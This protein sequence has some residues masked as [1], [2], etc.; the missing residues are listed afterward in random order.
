MIGDRSPR[1]GRALPGGVLLEL[2][3]RRRVLQLDL[4][5][6][7]ER[8]DDDAEQERDPPAPRRERFRRHERD[9]DEERQVRQDDRERRA[10]LGEAPVEAPSVLWRVLGDHQQRAAVLPADGDAL[11]AAQHDQQDRREDAGR[12]VGGEHAD[13]RGRRT[14]HH[15]RDD[16]QLLA[17]QPVSEVS[18]Q[19]AADRPEQEPDAERGERGQRAERRVDLRE[20]HLVEHQRRGGAVDVEVEPLERAGRQRRHRDPAQRALGRFRSHIRHRDPHRTRAGAVA[21]AAVAQASRVEERTTPASG[22]SVTHA[23]LFNCAG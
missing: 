8:D 16:E 18:E 10:D 22:R 11:D 21:D 15:H 1:R 12:G 13:Q 23:R 17:P 3:E 4:D 2:P 14:H 7:P 9:Q 5:P 20:E 6:E 19:D